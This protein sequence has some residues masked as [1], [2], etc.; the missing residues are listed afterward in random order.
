MYADVS[1]AYFYARA[2]RP[3]YVQL[4]E[5]DRAEGDEGL[6]G[7]LNVSMYGTRDAALNWATEYG[8]TLIDA[9]YIQGKSCPCLFWHPQKQVTI[10]VHGDD[11][12]AVGLEENLAEAPKDIRR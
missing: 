6:C 8:G 1:R 11:F 9:G 2:I 10:M 4:T 12:A 3:V 7:R 5:E